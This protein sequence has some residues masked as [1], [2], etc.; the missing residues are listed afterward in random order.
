MTTRRSGA[1]EPEGLTVT[2]G[3]VALWG[4]LLL[5]SLWLKLVSQLRWMQY[6]RVQKLDPRQHRQ[7][8]VYQTASR[9][10]PFMGR[11]AL[12]MALF[13]TYA[14]PSISRI[15][16]GTRQFKD[17]CVKRY[18]DTDFLLREIIENSL[19]GARGQAALGG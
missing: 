18:D 12:E 2:R 6:D 16:A 3:G 19:E 10:F 7:Q 8:I 11:V 4:F 1:A 9:E 5:L 15:L 14:I 17:Q 13:R